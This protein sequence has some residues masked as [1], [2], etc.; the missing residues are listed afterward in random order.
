MER[1]TKLKAS[2]HWGTV[3]IAGLSAAATKGDAAPPMSVVASPLVIASMQCGYSRDCTGIGDIKTATAHP[4]RQPLYPKS[5]SWNEFLSS[6]ADFAAAV[7]DTVPAAAKA[8]KYG[9]PMANPPR[10][11]R[12]DLKSFRKMT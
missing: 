3:P 10:I 2:V 8:A 11:T 4:T 6:P 12:P 5:P 1:V 7:A 9:S